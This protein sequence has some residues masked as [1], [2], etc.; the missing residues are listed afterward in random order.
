MNRD[1]AAD[2]RDEKGTPFCLAK[3][4]TSSTIRKIGSRPIRAMISSS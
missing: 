2:P 3:F 1:E 4:K